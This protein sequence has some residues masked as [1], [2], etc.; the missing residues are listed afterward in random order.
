M[1]ELLSPSGAV[2]VDNGTILNAMFEISWS[3]KSVDSPLLVHR[4]RNSGKSE[5]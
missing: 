3:E 2:L 4:L 5:G 1:R